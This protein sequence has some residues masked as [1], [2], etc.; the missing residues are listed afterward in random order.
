MHKIKAFKL[1]ETFW[2]DKNAK[3]AKNDSDQR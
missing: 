1:H 3:C 2:G